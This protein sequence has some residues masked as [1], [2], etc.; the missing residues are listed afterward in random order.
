MPALI[1]ATSSDNGQVDAWPFDQFT[2]RVTTSR[3]A[4]VRVMK[5]GSVVNWMVL[6]Q[7]L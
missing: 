1:T 6:N 4:T 3:Y 5:G 2:T 7:H